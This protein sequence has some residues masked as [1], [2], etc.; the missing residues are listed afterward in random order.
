MAEREAKRESKEHASQ[1]LENI[2]R[3]AKISCQGADEVECRIFAPNAQG[4]P[5][6]VELSESRFV[7]RVQVDATTMQHLNLGQ[8]DP[9][10]M[11]ELRSAIMAVH[12]LAGRR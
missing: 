12:R 11:R 6:T 9:N 4:H 1:R 7:R 2:V 5:Y 10:L 3:K 8:P